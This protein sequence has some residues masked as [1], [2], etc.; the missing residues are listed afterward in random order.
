MCGIVGI[1]SKNNR[2]IQERY[3][4]AILEKQYHRGPDNSSKIM[5]DDVTLGHNR[6]AII[7]LNAN[8]PF[9]SNCGRYSIVFNG[10]IWS[11]KMI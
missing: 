4:D 1:W 2:E 3:V 8:Q 9:T 11:L 7:D 5:V 6:L 10:E